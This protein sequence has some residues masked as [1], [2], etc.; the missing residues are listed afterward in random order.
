[1]PRRFAAVGFG[2]L[3]VAGLAFGVRFAAALILL[4]S[5]VYGLLPSLLGFRAALQASK[6]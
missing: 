6:R 5:F 2:V 3:V 1:M 4:A